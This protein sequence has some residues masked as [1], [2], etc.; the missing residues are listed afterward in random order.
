M[1]FAR[2]E[3][4]L[5]GLSL[6]P[7]YKNFFV[8]KGKNRRGRVVILGFDGVE[9]TIVKKMLSEKKLP[10]IANLIARGVFTSLNTTIPPQSPTA[11][12]SFATSKNP[13]AH[14]IYDFIKRDPATYLPGVSLGMV[15]PPEFDSNGNLKKAPYFENYRKGESFWKVADEYGARCKVINMPYCFPPD[16]LKN[17]LMLSGLGVPDI[18]GTE[19]FFYAFSDRFTTEELNKDISGGTKIKLNF[20]GNEA[21]VEFSVSKNPYEK[22]SYIKLSLVFIKSKESNGQIVIKL[23]DDREIILKEGEWS[24]WIEWVFK[25]PNTDYTIYAISRFWAREVGEHTYIY[26]TP[27][28]YHPEHPIIPITSPSSYSTEL[29]KRYGLYKT[30]GWNY[31]THALRQDV[32]TED[33]FIED[34]KKTMSWHEKLVLDEIAKGDFDLMIGMWMATDRVA[35]LFWRFRDPT[36]PMFEEDK[37][38]LYGEVLEE[39]YKIMDRIVGNVINCISQDDLLILM[40]DHGFTSYNRGFNLTTWLIREG[41]LVVEGQKDSTTAYN[42]Q[43]YLQGYDWMKTKAYAL[44]LG[45]IYL[46]LEGREGEGI[47]NRAE[48]NRL[49]D[50]IRNKLLS[51]KDPTTG[52][53]IVKNVYTK[54]NYS[55]IS[56]SSAPDL[57]VGYCE[58]YQTTKASAKGSAPK[59]IVE[60]NRDKWSGDH[61]GTAYE[62]IPGMFISNIN[63]NTQPDIKDIAPTTL[64]FLGIQ[65]PDDFEGKSLI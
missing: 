43:P 51:V 57:I 53:P 19:S 61:V 10:S 18:R 46:N 11:W 7:I 44:G 62:L 6:Y 32:I 45:S 27:F 52:K 36:H 13:G 38:R 63:I 59:D 5:G 37:A 1:K 40:S 14:G 35:H 65:I 50:E 20:Q 28:Q 29:A 8:S 34:V 41:Y 16:E 48:Y 3:F 25:V 58:G 30:I 47:V 15:H 24:Q 31:D 23:P 26:M 42:D 49:V 9:P 33:F 4:L 21:K 12:S 17:G 55:G 60:D 2:R 64:S 54:K 56:L 22:K 39:T